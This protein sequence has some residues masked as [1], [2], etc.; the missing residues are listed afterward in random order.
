QLLLHY[1]PKLDLATMRPTGAEALVRWLHPREGL[2][3]P[4]EFIPLAEHTGLIRPLGLWVL[5]AA[6]RR[7]RMWHR[8]GM[9]LNVAVNLGADSLQDPD[10]VGTITRLLE[11]SDV[12]PSWLTI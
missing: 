6:L 4:A 11:S 7:C 3:S 10:L 12:S 8:S 5:N 9:D 2:I 1:Q